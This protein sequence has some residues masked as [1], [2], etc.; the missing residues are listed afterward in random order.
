MIKIIESFYN[1]RAVKLENFDLNN[2]YKLFLDGYDCPYLFRD[3]GEFIMKFDKDGLH[4]TEELNKA[5]AD[6]GLLRSSITS[7]EYEYYNNIKQLLRK[8]FE[9]L[10]SSRDCQTILEIL[11]ATEKSSFLNDQLPYHVID[12]Y[13]RSLLLI[14]HKLKL[15]IDGNIRNNEN[16][17][18]N[19]LINK[20]LT[21][22]G[23]CTYKLNKDI[24]INLEYERI[25]TDPNEK[26]CFSIVSTELLAVKSK[27]KLVNLKWNECAIF[28]NDELALATKRIGEPSKI[29]IM[30]VWLNSH[31]RYVIKFTPFK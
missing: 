4:I 12:E 11:T 16:R 24:N 5:F 21:K 9:T 7:E 26:D 3:K 27:I 1:I 18:Y 31:R 17:L 10:N 20:T 23:T 14:M 19:Y 29:I 15:K 13:S 8:S 2:F 22:V 6:Y 25:F 30:N 28:D